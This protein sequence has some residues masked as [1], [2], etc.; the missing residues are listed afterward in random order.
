MSEYPRDAG[1]PSPRRRR[2]DTVDERRV[3]DVVPTA[4]DDG[5]AWR[6]D[7]VRRVAGL[8]VRPHGHR[9]LHPTSVAS[10]SGRPDAAS[11]SRP[12][13]SRT[14][15]RRYLAFLTTREYA[16]RSIARKTAS[17]RRY[18]RWLV[19][20]GATDR[21][22]DGRR[23]GTRRRRPPAAGARP[24]DLDALLEGPRPEDEPA[25]RRTT[26]RRRAGGALRL[27]VCGSASS[28]GSTSASIDLDAG[29]GGGVGQGAQGAPGPA[30]RSR[31]S[32]RCG[33]GWRSAH[34]VVPDRGRSGVGAVRQRARA[35]PDARGTC[36]G[37]SIGDRPRRRT[38]TRCATASPPICST[39]A[40]TCGRCR[41]CWATPTSRRRSATPT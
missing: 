25:W 7:V 18:F 27:R 26:R 15:I 11:P 41:S 17:L 35:A 20:A 16:R 14:T 29:R 31:R 8:A 1:R 4:D 33:R 9:L 32:P 38:R 5:S 13:C 24:R 30:V 19:R 23:A 36:A 34:E 2:S 6:V 37:S 28:V 10:P 21:R 40:P 22:S 39:A 12:R 3:S